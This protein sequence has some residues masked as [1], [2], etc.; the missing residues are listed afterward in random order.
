MNGRLLPPCLILLGV[1]VQSSQGQINSQPLRQGLSAD[2]SRKAITA[3]EMSLKE[4]RIKTEGAAAPQADTREYVVG[5]E[6]LAEKPSP[7]KDATK[8]K[9]STGPKAVVTTYRYFDDMTIMATVD[10][11][12][13]K[14][15]D[16]SAAQ[17]IRT[18]LSDF[19]YEECQ[20]LARE[21]L[22]DV[23]LIYE[24]LGDKVQVYPQFSQYTPPGEERV[25]RVVYL[26]YRVGGRD[27]S[28]PRPRIDLTTREVSI[29]PFPQKADG[30]K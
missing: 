5:V 10:L 15:I 29:K 7:T 3:A 12:T 11:T 21:K 9:G 2:Q 27:L 26:T 16:V 18:P 8:T 25:H 17:H 24:K 30:V 6:L 20:R 28:S 1:F 23:K 14:T 4:L 19:E 22:D 13:G